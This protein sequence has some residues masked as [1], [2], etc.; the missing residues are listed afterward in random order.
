MTASARRLTAPLLAALLLF[1]GS[2]P[3]AHADEDSSPQPTDSATAEVT[4]EDEDTE[5][6]A[7][8]S[9]LEQATGESEHDDVTY[10]CTSARATVHGPSASWNPG[11]GLTIPS[12]FPECQRE[13][14]ELVIEAEAFAGAGIVGE[15]R[16]PD[17]VAVVRIEDSAF[18][19][20]SITTLTVG[21]SRSVRVGPDAFADPQP[22][23]GQ[24]DYEFGGWYT[25]ADFSGEPVELSTPLAAGSYYAEW[26][27]PEAD[28]PLHEAPE[29]NSTRPSRVVQG[30][31]IHWGIEIVPSADDQ[32]PADGTVTIYR[33][34]DEDLADPL[35]SAEIGEDFT[36]ELTV[37]SSVIDPGSRP[38]LL[39]YSGSEYRED[40]TAIRNT[41]IMN[42]ENLTPTETWAEPADSVIAPGES[43][44]FTVFTQTASGGS[45]NTAGATIELY[46]ADD[47]DREHVIA[48]E[49]VTGYSAPTSTDFSIENLPSGTYE[50]IA[51]LTGSTFVADSESE[52]FSVTVQQDD[53]EVRLRHSTNVSDRVLR[54]LDHP[55]T[56]TLEPM[57]DLSFDDLDVIDGTLQYPL[58]QPLG[59]TTRT[60]SPIVHE[61]DI[62]EA[63][64]AGDAYIDEDG[65]LVVETMLPTGTD[66][67]RLDRD[68][69]AFWPPLI[70]DSTHIREGA[71]VSNTR[72]VRVSDPAV[73][74]DQ[75][76]GIAHGDDAVVT[77]EVAV[78]DDYP[79][80][81]LGGEI[82][83]FVPGGSDPVAVADLN[84]ETYTAE[85][86]IP[87]E[88]VEPGNT[89]F[90]ARH[91]NS[92]TF[93][94]SAGGASVRAF[95]PVEA[96][97]AEPVIELE[98]GQTAAT[99][100]EID[101]WMDY[102][103]GSWPG[104][105]WVPTGDFHLYT[106]EGGEP[107]EELGVIGETEDEHSA[108][109][110]IPELNHG[111]HQFLVLYRDD[112]D[113]GT[114]PALL[115]TGYE[116]WSEAVE[117]EVLEAEPEHPAWDAETVYTGGETVE[118]DDRLFEA[119]WWTQNQVPGE[120][121]TSAWSEIGAPTVCESGTYPA[122]APSTEFQG[123]ETVVFE[124]T[125]YTAQWYS[126]NQEPG[127]QWGPWEED[128]DC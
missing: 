56:T 49:E 105:S 25:T 26:T 20:N 15:L 106:A 21:S 36:A 45:Y 51:V 46:E 72:S 8:Q 13:T 12:S 6:T 65:L 85:V 80:Q 44:D 99:D 28:E 68:A 111:E 2:A 112:N 118:Y 94:E 74:T 48:A 9:E 79:H 75:P 101:A 18:T 97:A 69:N 3:A 109:L 73:S 5:E 52:V 87:A 31:P 60:N 50:Y 71:F 37:D 39:V 63:Y 67:V 119:L 96:E 42:P 62:A 103:A 104:G 35:D 89:S 92:E 102:P 55:H 11:S 113:E 34:S 100:V 64:Q 16:L 38:F 22:P 43:F 78:P 108:T 70:T 121:A 58:G 30:D 122:W 27:A 19:T 124:G 82:G 123:G 53:L 115:G 14:G 90:S 98:P 83:I 17:E 114:T 1:P 7:D 81:V 61:V 110:V 125:V 32:S 126:R 88:A 76:I 40:A 91:I 54:G 86:T 128:E 47:A 95:T 59:G 116:G 66:T 84:L 4:E 29:L 41:F 117:I 57:G 10:S 93:G 120:S 24:G 23:A 107:G 77:A 33:R 127:D